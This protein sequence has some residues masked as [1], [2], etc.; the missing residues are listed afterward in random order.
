MKYLIHI[1]I[2]ALVLCLGNQASAQT[3]DEELAT[4]YYQNGEYEKALLYFEDIY[5]KKPSE[6]NFRFYLNSLKELDR[7]EEAEKL[8]KRHMK[9][10][11]NALALYIELGGLQELQG[12]QDEAD[13]NY[14]KAIKSIGQ[15]RNQVI[16]LANAFSQANKLN[17]A[18]RTYDEGKKKV[19]NYPFSYEVASLYGS[20][21]QH[22]KMIDEYMN[23]L[24]FNKG[25]LRSVQNNLNRTLD[26][27]SEDDERVGILKTALLKNVQKH[28][29]Q[30]VFYEML[31]WLFTQRKEFNAAYIQT[32]AIDKRQGEDGRRLISLASLCTNN[33]QYDVAAKCYA[34]IVDEKGAR[35]R[36]YD[37]AKSLELVSAK[38]ALVSTFDPPREEVVALDNRFKTVVEELGPGG[39]A[40]RMM[41][42]RAMLNAFYLGESEAAIT[43]LDNAINSPGVDEKLKA[44][45][46]L[47]LGD[48]L[49]TQGY[50]WDASLYYSQVEK[51]FKEDVLGFDAK[52]RNARISYFAGDFDWAQAQLDVLKASTSK[53]ISNDAMDL[54]LLITDNLNLDTI[55]EPME[56]FARADLLTF[57]NK[58]D[59]ATASLDSI[60]ENYPGHTLEDEI[61]YQKAQIAYKQGQFDS[62]VVLLDEILT[63]YF[64]DILADNALFELAE[65]HEKIFKD[66]DKA[67]DYYEKLIAEFP[68]SLYVIEARKRFRRLR[69][70]VPIEEQE[71]FKPIDKGEDSLDSEPEGG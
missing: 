23:L 31:I 48:I 56:M 14:N 51:D 25:Y 59:L 54:S 45:C 47:D 66:E 69:G 58:F 18:L 11:Q 21:G 27:T 7:L 15:N 29:E 6:A 71:E 9:K 65:I 5:K 70:D 57:Q 60:S 49:L 42:E 34:Y 46:K 43:L 35:S 22:E 19:A 50:I 1:F 4:Y 38:K 53:L 26:F 68:A 55:Y 52:Y 67:K 32:K 20:M 61:I 37:T 17:L 12:R 30:N 63:F 28:P 44:A 8:C 10:N 39:E 41:R 62:T 24:S 13:D 33:E 3:T 16:E 36:Y 64:D 40:A 2:L